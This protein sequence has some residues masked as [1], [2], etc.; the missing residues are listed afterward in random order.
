MLRNVP[1]SVHH[2]FSYRNLSVLIVGIYGCFCLEVIIKSR[3]YRESPT[4]VFGFDHTRGK[5]IERYA[6]DSA[7]ERWDCVTGENYACDE[8]GNAIWLNS[9]EMLKRVVKRVEPTLPMLGT[10]RFKGITVLEVLIDVG[11]KVRCA[12]VI[13]GSSLASSAVLASVSKWKFRPYESNGRVQPVLGKL[14]IPY[15]IKGRQH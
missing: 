5:N 7:L 6:E 4:V 8:Q 13:K 9:T 11:G 3:E 2:I 12:R 10:G 15:D 1:S 14:K